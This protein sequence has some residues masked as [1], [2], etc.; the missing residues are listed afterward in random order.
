MN[1]E[2]HQAELDAERDVETYINKFLWCVIGFFLGPIGILIAFLNQPIPKAT[3]LIEKSDSYKMT[4]TEIYRSKG[5]KKQCIFA[6]VGFGIVLAFGF[7]C[8][9][10]LSIV[11]GM[12]GSSI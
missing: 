8:F 7:F 5:K 11:I 3:S 12:I 2:G 4:Y 9:L 1:N 10:F 6:V